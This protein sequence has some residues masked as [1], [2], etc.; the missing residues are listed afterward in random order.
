MQ[1]EQLSTIT[2]GAFHDLCLAWLDE[3]GCAYTRSEDDTFYSETLPNLVVD[4]LDRIPHRYDAVIVDEGQ[5]FKDSSWTLMEFLFKNQNEAVFYIFADA[6]Q[7]IYR[8]TSDYPMEMFPVRLDKN[9]R[10][11]DPVFKIVKHACELPDDIESSGVTGPGVRFT[12]YKDDD[13]MMPQ[14]ESVIAQLIQEGVSPNDIAVL[15]TRSQSRTALQYGQMIGP[16]KLVEARDAEN[17]IVTMTI[18]RFKGLES[19]V[20]ILCELD[21]SVRHNH[22]ELMYIGLTR[23]TGLMCVLA[24]ESAAEYYKKMLGI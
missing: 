10:N 1:C 24:R 20:V 11:T 16:F 3:I 4:H 17:Q 2:V 7:N 12:T 8:G 23:A 6:G 19:P 9:L 21:E 5:D 18:H 22:K 14:L 15:G 13:C